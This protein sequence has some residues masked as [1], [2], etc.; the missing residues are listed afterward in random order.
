MSPAVYVMVWMN[1]TVVFSVGPA[2][3]VLVN[4]RIVVYEMG[5]PPDR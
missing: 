5:M 3:L 1:E 2:T 4:P